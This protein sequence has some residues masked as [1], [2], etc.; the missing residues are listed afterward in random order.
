MWYDTMERQRMTCETCF[1]TS[2]Y[3]CETPLLG[4]VQERLYRKGVSPKHLSPLCE[5]PCAL[6]TISSALD[7][8]VLHCSFQCLSATGTVPRKV[9]CI[10]SRM[11]TDGASLWQPYIQHCLILLLTYR[12]CYNV[13]VTRH[14]HVCLSMCILCM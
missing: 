8:A 4:E 10:H 7:H 3:S 12:K 11:Q 5:C 9:D 14:V 1:C 2:R 6:Q 13:T